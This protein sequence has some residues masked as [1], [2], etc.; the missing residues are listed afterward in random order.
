MQPV[1]AIT[2]MQSFPLH[3]VNNDRS[4]LA[5][6][7]GQY[8]L[9]ERMAYEAAGGHHAVRDRFVEDI[10]IAERVKALGLPIRVAL[11]REIVTCRMYASFGQVVRG[12]SRI[13]YDALGRAPMAPHSQTSRSDHLLPERPPGARRVAGAAGAR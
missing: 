8:I 4:P 1:A 13:L 12:W 6:A 5:F 7:N 3:T 10:A 2:L 9:I 11:A